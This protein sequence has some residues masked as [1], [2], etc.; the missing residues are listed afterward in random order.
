MCVNTRSPSGG[1][2]SNLW[3]LAA[4]INVVCRVALIVALYVYLCVIHS[5]VLCWKSWSLEACA[6]LEEGTW[7][8][9]GGCGCL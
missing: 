8:L 5:T 3:K 1:S 4:H 6:A 9:L 7:V 2:Q